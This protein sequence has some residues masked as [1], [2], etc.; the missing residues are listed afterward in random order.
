[1]NGGKGV[2]PPKDV[3]LKCLAYSLWKHPTSCPKKEACQSVE[4]PL[5]A[6]GASIY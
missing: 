3:S 4:V 5:A 2:Q 6:N 1:M